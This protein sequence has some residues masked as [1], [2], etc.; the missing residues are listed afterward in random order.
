MSK[1]TTVLLSHGNKLRL[2]DGTMFI[3]HSYWYAQ[4]PAFPQEVDVLRELEVEV[5]VPSIS[6]RTLVDKASVSA[7]ST[8]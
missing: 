1:G 2:C 5:G 8:A 6:F 7:I 4:K 3:Y